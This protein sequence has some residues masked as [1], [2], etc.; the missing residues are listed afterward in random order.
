MSNKLIPPVA[1][2]KVLQWYPFAE[3]EGDVVGYGG[4]ERNGPSW[5]EG[6]WMGGYAL[7]A[8]GTDDNVVT[9]TWGEFPERLNKEPWSFA[10]TASD[11]SSSSGRI[12]G[13]ED[14]DGVVFEIDNSGSFNGSQGLHIPQF[15]FR[16]LDPH[17]DF[18]SYQCNTD[19]RDVDTVRMVFTCEGLLTPSN[20]EWWVDGVS[21][22]LH[23]TG[24]L[25]EDNF[26]DDFE[27]FKAPVTFFSKNDVSYEDMILDDIIVYGD[28]LT[29]SEIQADYQRQP[30]S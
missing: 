21:D 16:L 27:E 23:V 22:G 25:E 17:N 2:E 24:G 7:D 30:W 18:V 5:V 10:F 8:D 26:E 13:T 15:T 3:G 12:M 1:E 9:T 11:Y 14:D 6:E 20:C 19:L 4:G 28:S 29:P